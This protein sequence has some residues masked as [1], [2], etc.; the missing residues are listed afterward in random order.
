[1]KRDH[2]TSAF[3][4]LHLARWTLHQMASPCRQRVVN[5][6]ERYLQQQGWETDGHCSPISSQRK[7]GA[8]KCFRSLDCKSFGL[9]QR[10]LSRSV[11]RKRRV[12]RNMDHG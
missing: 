4:R 11:N 10:G 3:T 1:M 7:A 5:C 8:R 2:V 6:S 12:S 9:V